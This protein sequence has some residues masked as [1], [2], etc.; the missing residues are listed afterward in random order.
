MASR[1]LTLGRIIGFR[2]RTAE[3][4]IR[5]AS[6][7]PERWTKVEQVFLV[8]S[9]E[10]DGGSRKLRKVRS[11][12]C[13]GNRL[14]LALDGIDDPSEAARLKGALV[15]VP[16]DQVPDPGE[17]VFYLAHVVG[18]TVVDRR[19]GEI[20]IVEDV[21]ETGGV[22]LLSVRTP[23]RRE[24]LIPMAPEILIEVDVEGGIARVDLPEGLL[25]LDRPAGESR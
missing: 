21:I 25:D 14:V 10:R 16:A 2:T 24:V 12:R 13:Y 7:H 5:V 17:G 4:A 20:G 1:G 19:L 15:E 9:G 3:V 6:G 23:D 8:A 11:A 22:D 18:A